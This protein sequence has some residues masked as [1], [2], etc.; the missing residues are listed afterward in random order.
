[1]IRRRKGTGLADVNGK[2]RGGFRVA[3]VDL[4]RVAGYTLDGR[5]EQTIAVPILTP[6]GVCFGG[7]DSRTMHTTS[8]AAVA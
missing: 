5:L 1:L 2:R 7:S 3:E 6:T 4:R 8:P